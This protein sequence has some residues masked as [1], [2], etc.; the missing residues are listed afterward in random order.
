MAMAARA[1]MVRFDGPNYGDTERAVIANHPFPRCARGDGRSRDGLAAA[2][3]IKRRWRSTLPFVWAQHSHPIENEAE[4]RARASRARP[5]RARASRARPCRA[6]PCGAQ[7]ALKVEGIAPKALQSKLCTAWL[8]PRD[9]DSGCNVKLAQQRQKR[10]VIQ[11]AG[12]LEE[13]SDD[14]RR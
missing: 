10:G 8:V 6:R 1:M 7:S 14:A 2:V 5:C 3:A 4:L 12:D 13:D 11:V 9:D